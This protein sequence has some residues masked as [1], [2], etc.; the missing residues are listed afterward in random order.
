[1]SHVKF[2]F[3]SNQYALTYFTAK[4]RSVIFLHSWPQKLYR[5]LR[6]GTHLCS[7]CLDLHWFSSWLGNFWPSGGQKHLEGG[8]GRAPSQ[9][10]VFW[11]FFQHALTLN[12]RGPSYLDLT[13][14][15]RWL[16]MPWLLM[17]PGHQQPWYWLC[18]ISRSGLTWGR[19]LTHWGRDKLD[20]ISQTTFS[21]VFSWMK[22][23]EFRLEF[24]W[25]MF[26]SDWITIIQHWFRW[27]LGAVQATSHYLNQWWLVYRCIYASFGLNELSTC[28]I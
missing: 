20:A 14:S 13:R 10:T 5:G 24:H 7:E 23:F 17:S 12:V 18:R 4:N 27:W 21:N 6:F 3:H 11:T 25:S 8:V 19:I 22:M 16:L 15:I 28:V 26:P 1:M 2:E 9:R